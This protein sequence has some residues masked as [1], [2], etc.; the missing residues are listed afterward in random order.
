MLTREALDNALP[1]A[2]VLDQRGLILRPVENTA[3]DRLVGAT[4]A[5]DNFNYG[6]AG[7]FTPDT[8]SMEFIANKVDDALGMSPH[9]FAM[10]ADLALAIPAVRAHI[11]F[12]K[13]V[14]APSV[15]DLVE[16]VKKS[17]VELTPSSLLGM[18]VIVWNPASPLLNNAFVNIARQF[19]EVPYDVPAM[20]IQLPTLP[21]SEIV[22]LMKTG[23]ASVD[24]DIAT[25]AAGK[26]E[27]FFINIWEN[28]FQMKPAELN[29]RIPVKFSNF[30]DDRE[31]GADNAIAIFLLA[32]RLF[33]APPE[34][35]EMNLQAFN[36]SMAEFRNQAGAR[37]C[38]E[39]DE[40]ERL[41][42]SKG[43]I[44]AVM[45]NKTVVNGPVYKEW[46]EAGGSNEILFGN[47]LNSN[48]VFSAELL[49][50][51]G[52]GLKLAWQKHAALTAAV[53]SNRQF[54]RVKEL[55]AR[56]FR[57]QMRDVTEGEEATLANREAVVRL[58][59]EE[60]EKIRASE[61][62]DLWS[63]TLRIVCRSRFFRTDAER[64]LTDI[65]E[66]ARKN[67]G[68]DEREAAG[69]AALKYI[70]FWVASQFKVIAV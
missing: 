13:T 45:D 29:D 46:L 18:E 36:N 25:W 70:S 58:F 14:V 16:R 15:A 48:P 27:S 69:V 20:N 4:R 64:I 39:L 34:G 22:E 24:D 37:I 10:D 44:R 31:I 35:T 32:R 53:E 57:A 2:E 5:D 11:S 17:L 12:A 21:V 60:L 9:D 50:E 66:I 41:M 43:V 6:Q 63:L 1:L 59:D 7:N 8:D 38:R 33:D 19:E 67:P 68:I 49:N 55:M 62:D 30:I 40:L 26:G 42:K 51:Q 65:E 52:D 3:L 56:H 47:M 23:T 61:L 28:V 54:A